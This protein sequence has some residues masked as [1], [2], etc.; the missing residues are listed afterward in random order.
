MSETDVENKEEEKEEE[1][2]C[3]SHGSYEDNLCP[4]NSGIC[5]KVSS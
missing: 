5:Q 1:M 3:A 4:W 2:E